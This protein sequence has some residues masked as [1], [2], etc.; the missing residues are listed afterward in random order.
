MLCEAMA[1]DKNL[2]ELKFLPDDVLGEVI[3]EAETMMQAQLQSQLASDQRAFTFSGIMLTAATAALGA[4]IALM[5]AKLP[6]YSLARISAVFAIGMAVA[7]GVAL[8]TA[9][10]RP[11][12]M[13]GNEP[14]NWHP[15]GWNLADRERRDL[16]HARIE[17]AK[18][19]QSQ[20]TQNR[21]LARW[22]ARVQIT[23]FAIAYII[24]ALCGA[25]VLATRQGLWSIV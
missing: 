13:P 2:D 3:R 5:Q 9:W 20:I 12:C 16:R 10:P 23:S 11:F 4:T 22:K 14:K 1:G 8:F 21:L 17:Q 24:T 6:D 18:V 15:D 19:L 25:W 7:A